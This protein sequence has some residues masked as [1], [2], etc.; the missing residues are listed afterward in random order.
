MNRVLWMNKWLK[1]HSFLTWLQISNLFSTSS[2]VEFEAG[3]R[4]QL[5]SL[6]AQM[7]MVFTSQTY[8]GRHWFPRTFYIRAFFFHRLVHES[9][10]MA[11]SLLIL[12]I[13][14]LQ[15][16][17]DIMRVIKYTFRWSWSCTKEAVALKWSN[18]LIAG[19]DF[20][21]PLLRGFLSDL[22]IWIKVLVFL[23]T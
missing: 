20:S 2:L 10:Y 19:S 18:P 3:D 23:K 16:I 13:L 12:C 17:Q 6:W 22:C 7:S 21:Q 9:C 14:I 4:T 1:N 11:F 15:N 8:N 5:C